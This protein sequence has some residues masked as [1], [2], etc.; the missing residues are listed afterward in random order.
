MHDKTRDEL[1]NWLITHCNVNTHTEQWVPK[2]STDTDRAKL[3]ISIL[4]P[5]LGQV[6]V[7]VT[8]ID[9]ITGSEEKPMQGLEAAERRKQDK[10]RGGGLFVF[11]IDVRGKWG[12]EAD[13]FVKRMIQNLGPKERLEANLDLRR[14]VAT[15]IHCG[16][17][18]QIITGARPATK[19]HRQ[20]NRW[21]DKA[22]RW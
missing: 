1:A 7:V 18:D 5:T 20:S 11:A 8:V 17:A 9:S 12:N 10:Y 14:R 4:D 15:T 22:R 6:Y 3:D 2:W 13:K 21:A 16:G 19:M